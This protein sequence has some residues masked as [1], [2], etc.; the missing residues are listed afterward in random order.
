MR[1]CVIVPHYD[2]VEQ[3]SRML[4]QLQRHG[5]ALIVV[6]DAS[7]E[8]VFARL[9]GL[10]ER[11]AP[12][13]R[14]V[15]HTENLGK[16]GAVMSGLIAARAAGYSHALQ[17]DADGQHDVDAIPR[18]LEIGRRYPDSL[19]CGEPVF[20]KDIS[21][22]RYYARHL[23]LF[24]C[25]AETLSL[26]IRDPMCGFRLYPL[27]RVVPIIERGGLGKRM[28][29]DPEIL[30]RSVWS[31]IP[32]RYLEVAVRYP[33]DGRSHFHYLGDNI[34]ISWMH[35]RMIAG[36][37]LRAP[38]LVWKRLSASRVREGV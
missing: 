15:R 17:L 11:E 33:E 19:V 16:G 18:F 7:E 28:A 22:L 2:H 30:V 4:P 1:A 26:Q 6:D 5:L 20:G 27:A 38:G 14:L 23:T 13:A 34:E 24:L 10:L 36:M 31:G 9:Q 29:F 8:D 37:L 35:T 32:L 3:F 21:A 12:G 25:W